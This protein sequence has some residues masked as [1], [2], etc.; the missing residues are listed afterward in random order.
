MALSVVLVLPSSNPDFPLLSMREVEEEDM[1]DPVLES[2]P[3]IM[4][5][6]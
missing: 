1:V 3:L 6:R 5:N 2:P 4:D